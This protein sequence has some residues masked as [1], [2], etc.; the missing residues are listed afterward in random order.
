MHSFEEIKVTLLNWVPRLIIFILV[1]YIGFLL[2][3]WLMKVLERHLRSKKLNL[4]ALGFFM[5]ILNFFLKLLVVVVGLGILDVPM[6]SISAVVGAATLSIGLALQGSLSNLAGGL[7]LVTTEPFKLGDFIST[8]GYEGTVEEIAI[9]TTKLRTLDGKRV[10]I[11]NSLVSSSSIVNYSVYDLR[12]K[13]IDL[14]ISYEADI[15]LVKRTLLEAT[16]KIEA[17]Q[18]PEVFLRGYGE[19]GFEF[20]LRIWLPR[21]SLL[22]DSNALNEL[23]KPA[24]DQAKI[25]LAYPHLDIEIVGGFNEEIH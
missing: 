8:E 20:T 5:S 6:A 2:V 23:I 12:R 14:V 21:A 22:K 18:N 7:V 24:L 15:E 19:Q 25:N 3:S 4:T 16:K 9:L 11:P 1:V 10:I 13:D 17:I